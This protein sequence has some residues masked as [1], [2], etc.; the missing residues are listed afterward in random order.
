MSK[1]YAKFSV[2]AT[3]CAFIFSCAFAFVPLPA[4]AATTYHYTCLDW[5]EGTATCSSDTLSF[6]GPQ[7]AVDGTPHFNLTAGTWYFSAN[8]TLTGTWGFTGVNDDF[9]IVEGNQVDTPFVSVLGGGLDITNNVGDVTDGT[10]YN[11]CVSD[12]SGACEG[13]PPTPTGSGQ[14]FSTTTQLVDNP[15][16]DFDVGYIMFFASMCFIIWLFKGR[17]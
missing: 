17:K 5:T 4:L 10:V 6:S 2:F 15:T 12:V 11:I 9:N 14:T 7:N 16:Q 3:S 1:I 8:T 13:V